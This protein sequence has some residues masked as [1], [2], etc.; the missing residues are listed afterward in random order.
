MRSQELQ[1]RPELLSLFAHSTSV[2]F[3]LGK[4]PLPHFAFSA[5]PQTSSDNAGQSK[6]RLYEGLDCHTGRLVPRP[7]VGTT[8]T[9]MPAS[10]I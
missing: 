9:A 8:C 7:L 4:V 5:Q 10:P 3:N 6:N 1:S 2:N